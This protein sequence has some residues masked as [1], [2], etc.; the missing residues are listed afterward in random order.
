MDILIIDPEN[1]LSAP[2]KKKIR[3]SFRE[4]GIVEQNE[5][6]RQILLSIYYPEGITPY[7]DVNVT[8]VKNNSYMLSFVNQEPLSVQPSREDLRKKL[9]EK[10]RNDFIERNNSYQDDAW[11]MYQTLL[12][13]PAIQALPKETLQK[14][15]P[16]PDDIRKNANAYQTINENNPNPVL[17]KYFNSCLNK[18]S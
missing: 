18:E 5:W 15:L 1:K 14:A 10:L 8:E 4:K 6:K 9:R 12:K 7:K 13:H 2:Q 11:K 17:K 3:V 16:T